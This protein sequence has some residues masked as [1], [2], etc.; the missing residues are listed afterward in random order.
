[1]T[2]TNIILKKDETV[3]EIKEKYY[4]AKIILLVLITIELFTCLN[5]KLQNCKIKLNNYVV[6]DLNEGYIETINLK[7]Y[8]S[9]YLF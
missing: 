8:N 4:G 3:K 9:S 5:I 1:M 6:Q 2:N 7:N